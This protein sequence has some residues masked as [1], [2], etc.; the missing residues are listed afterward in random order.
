M[1]VVWYGARNDDVQLR[2]YPLQ[3]NVAMC[4]RDSK[5]AVDGY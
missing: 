4:A 2:P 3:D 1:D 5:S